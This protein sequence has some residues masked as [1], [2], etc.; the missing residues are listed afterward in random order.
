[1]SVN[2]IN[3]IKDLK[4]NLP[5]YLE[6]LKIVDFH[7]KFTNE[8]K[9]NNFVNLNLAPSCFALKIYYM[10]GLW[11]TLENNKKLGWINFI[12]SFQTNSKIFPS[13]SFVDQNY[14]NSFNKI[15]FKK[16]LKNLVKSV[17]NIF[18]K[19][20]YVTNQEKLN[21]FIKA[22]SKQAISTLFQ[23]GHT[24]NKNYK[25]DFSSSK[26]L[27]NYL[28][29]LNWNKPWNA[30]AQFAGLCVF[31]KSQNKILNKN[32]KIRIL[33]VFIE[34]I[35]DNLT[36]AYFTGKQ[37][38]KKELINGTMKVLTGLEWLDIEPMYPN[39][40]IDTCLEINPDDEGCDL[41]DLV[42]VIYTCSKN[43]DYKKEEIKLYLINILKKI[44]NHYFYNIGGFS[45]FKDKS[46]T[47]YYGVKVSGGNN[48]PDIHGTVLL[49]W[50]V[51]MISQKLDL[52]TSDWKVLKP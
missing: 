41:V 22:E 20:K 4:K 14:L 5:N 47:H 46:Q 27:Q 40:L 17:L 43:S 38:S 21:D 12:N 44:E 33:K 29:N 10:I 28:E 24:N 1:M 31:L 26:E 16:Y 6:S 49:V 35:N 48:V 15:S 51:A 39:E 25:F 36:G 52:P 37:P 30:G 19:K 11:D 13:N 18:L 3:W 50:A 2:E 23:V 8:N 7:F 32:E 9:S 34:T 42:Y 45:Y